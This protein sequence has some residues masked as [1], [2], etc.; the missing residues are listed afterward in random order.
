[1]KFCCLQYVFGRDF[2]PDAVTFHQ[3]RIHREISVR[4]IRDNHFIT[5]VV[6]IEK[7][8]TCACVY[9]DEGAV[10]ER[11]PCLGVF[12]LDKGAVFALRIDR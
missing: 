4:T 9:V 5:P 11:D 3:C 8:K 6:L 10:P 12:R 2:L 1:M 7:G